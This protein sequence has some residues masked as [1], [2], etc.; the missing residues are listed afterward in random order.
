L[1]FL[2]FILFS[3]TASTQSYLDYP[4]PYHPTSTT[5]GMVVS[6]NY[7]SSDIGAMILSNGGNAVDAA[8]AVGFSLAATLP[9]AGNLGG[10]G[11]MMIYDAKSNSIAT[12]DFRSMSPELAES[13]KYRNK[14]K[15][16]GAHDYDLTRKGYKAIAVPGTVAGLI[17]AHEV[18]GSMELKD[19]IEPT[20]SL[21]KDGVPVTEDLFGAIQDTEYLTLDEESKKIYLNPDVKIGGKLF[22]ND[23]INTL[24]LISNNGVDGFYKGETAEK[25]ELAMIKHGGFI[26]KEDLMKYKPRFVPAISTNYRGNTIFTQGPPSGGGVAI[27]TSLNVLENFDLS[28]MNYDSGKYLH[29]LAEVMRFGHQSRSKYIGDPKF[30][31]IPMED[32]LSKDFAK[33]KSKSINL[34]R[35]SKPDRFNKNA[36]TLERKYIES[37]DTTHYSII[38]DNG[39]AVSVT[40]TLGYSFGSGVTIEGTG[41][42]GNNQMNNFAHE[43]G[44]GSYRRSAS[45]ANKLEPLKRPMSTMAPVMVFNKEGKLT[46]ITGSPGGSQIPNINLQVLINVLDFNLDIGEATMLPRIHQDSQELEL[47]LEKTINFDTRRYL[48]VFGHDIE[49][50]DT[51]GSTQSIH[52]V[53]NMRYGYS[54]LRRPN[55]KVSIKK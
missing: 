44:N 18:Y 19:L 45:P 30:S 27:L 55:A 54:D 50:S 47:L 43:Y 2:I 8:V 32:L 33:M 52:I 13:N 10:G 1:R 41:I 6:Q 46:L 49:V 31:N 7:L 29:L 37:K 3:L 42:L 21:L 16:N 12:L 28:K 17:K 48:G 51:I 23:L 4:H 40:Y 34:K 9:R 22:I 25:I 5:K 26:R 15:N 11:F 14:F 35:A 20:I 24:Q 38:D 53:D 36:Q 39:N